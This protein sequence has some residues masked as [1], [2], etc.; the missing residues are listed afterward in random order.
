MPVPFAS[1]DAILVADDVVVQFE[2]AEGPITAVDNVS[3]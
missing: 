2:T 3:F 1:N